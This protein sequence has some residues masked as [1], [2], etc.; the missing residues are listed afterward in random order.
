MIHTRL[1][2]TLLL[3]SSVCLAESPQYQHGISL[4][5]DLKYPPDFTHFAYSNP[6]AP[7]GGSL[8]LS[9][10]HPIRNFSGAWGMGVGSAPG[11]QRTN[12]RLFVKSA[13]ELSA[14]YGLLADG[15][16]LSA[17]RKSLYIRLNPAAR[18]HDG[19]PI[20]SHDVHFSYDVLASDTT[21]AIA[22]AYLGA[23]IESFE[24]IN[25]RELVIR[26]RDAFTHSN[27][28]AM[29]TFPVKPA[30]YYADRGDP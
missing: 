10:T 6:S 29:T 12:D 3:L 2:S 22:R 20:T 18:W 5:H 8:S 21:S 28:L 23:W 9:T 27:V 11:L 26:H 25:D 14:V 16:A 24:V 30:H 19:V 13:D 17:D 15:V 1:V 4:L 7:K